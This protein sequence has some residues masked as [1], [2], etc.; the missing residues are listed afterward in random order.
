LLEET[1]G[2]TSASDILARCEE[3]ARLRYPELL[4]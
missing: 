2:L 4:N 3:V 1:R